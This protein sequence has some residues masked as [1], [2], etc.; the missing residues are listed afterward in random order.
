VEP[1]STKFRSKG[2]EVGAM[3][4]KWP[5]PD[6]ESELRSFENLAPEQKPEPLKFSRLNQP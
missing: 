6:P 1:E 5:A 3:K 2:A 4:G